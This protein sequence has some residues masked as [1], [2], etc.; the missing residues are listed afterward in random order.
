MLTPSEGTHDH[1]GAKAVALLPDGGP[2]VALVRIDAIGVTAEVHDRALALVSDLGYRDETLLIS[3]TH[4]HSGPAAFFRAPAACLIAMDNF[5]PEVEER[6]AQACAAAIRS[7]HA[8]ARPATLAFARARDRG[9]QGE[10]RVAVNRRARRFRDA[11]AFDAVDDEIGAILLQDRED[12]APIALLANYAVHPTVLGSDNLYFSRDLAGGIED[13]LEA[14]VGA[15]ALFLN[16]AEG[17]V[18]PGRLEEKGGLTRCRELGEAFADLLL[19]ALEGAAPHAELQVFAA[20]G[21]KELGP[22]Y[23][24]VALGR[25]RF[26]DGDAGAGAWITAPLTLPVNALLWVLGFTNVRVALT[27]NLALGAVVDLQGLSDR[28]ETRVGALRLVAGDQDVCLLDPP[29]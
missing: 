15:P 18:G 10:L 1:V 29:R 11:I 28:T 5:R 19:P 7:A 4:T 25:S 22:M 26:I 14:R 2:P 9:A 13:A 16:G 17:D 23:T 6:I 21:R 24:Q 27:W 20:T 3:A 12:G 8:T